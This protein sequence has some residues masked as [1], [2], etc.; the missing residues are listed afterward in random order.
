NASIAHNAPLPSFDPDRRP[1]FRRPPDREQPQA[2]TAPRT[3]RCGSRRIFPLRTA[4]RIGAI[5]VDA[6]DGTERQPVMLPRSKVRASGAW[7]GEQLHPVKAVAHAATGRRGDAHLRKTRIHDV[8]AVIGAVEPALDRLL[9]RIRAVRN[10][11]AD[12]S[13]AVAARPYPVGRRLAG[14]ILV[15]EIVVLGHVG[16]VPE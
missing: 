5:K 4:K 16:G 9:D 10:V 1:P 7:F 8:L 13:L 15:L 6:A 12:Q 11:L 3:P 14:E 2:N